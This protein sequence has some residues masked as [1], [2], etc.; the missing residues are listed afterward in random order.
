MRV[1]LTALLAL[2]ALG[3]LGACGDNE[4]GFELY[5]VPDA[6]LAPVDAPID[7]SP[8]DTCVQ[9][10]AEPGD[11]CELLADHPAYVACVAVPAGHCADLICRRAD[12]SYIHTHVCTA[13]MD[14]GVDAP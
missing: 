3:A 2:V 12:C 9:P 1:L 6:Q 10:D 8:P 11:C 4:R 13:S 5:F 7:A 14:A